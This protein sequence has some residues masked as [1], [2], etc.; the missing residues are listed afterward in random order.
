M[1]YGISV[2]N[3]EFKIKSIY[4]NDFLKICKEYGYD[5]GEEG[6]KCNRWYFEVDEER[7]IINIEFHGENHWDSDEFLQKFATLVENN[8]FIEIIDDADNIW[9][10]VFN[11]NQ[12]IKK[13]PTITW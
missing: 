2:R 9:R 8:S 5:Y 10:W 4:Y 6:I 1:G 12:M 11:N 13:E 7:N 3:Q